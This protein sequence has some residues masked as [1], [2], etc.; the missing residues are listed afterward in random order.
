MGTR[1]YNL[2]AWRRLRKRVLERDAEVCL[3]HRFG[4]CDGP[5]HVHHTDRTA[6]PLD[7]DRLVSVCAHH[8]PMLEAVQR[9]AQKPEWKTCNHRHP[10][11][12]GK[13]EC[14]RRLNGLPPD[15]SVAA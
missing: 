8:H 3:L 13:R 14:E 6:D 4:G 7:E 9:R 2:P 11:S 5:L 1:L 12:I 10:Y 15:R